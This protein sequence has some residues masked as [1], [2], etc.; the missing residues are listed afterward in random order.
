LRWT[1]NEFAEWV[2]NYFQEVV[3]A[4]L[5]KTIK[6]VESGM[7]QILEN[8]KNCMSPKS[9]NS[10]GTGLADSLFFSTTMVVEVF[11]PKEI[12]GG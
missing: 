6:T 5:K 3:S 10:T 11:D 2:L 1:P 12:K 7:R 4:K 8:M 9:G